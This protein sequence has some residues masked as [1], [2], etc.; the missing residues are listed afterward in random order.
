[1][2]PVGRF[3]VG[4]LG[5]WANCRGGRRVWRGSSHRRPTSAWR[6]RPAA[7]AVEF[8]ALPSRRSRVITAS[9]RSL[10]WQ[11]AGDAVGVGVVDGDG[12]SGG[13]VTSMRIMRSPK[14]PLTR[15]GRQ[16]DR[17]PQPRRGE[18][19]VAAGPVDAADAQ[20][21]ERQRRQPVEAPD[22]STRRR[23]PRR[24]R[25]RPGRR[26]ARP[27]AGRCRA[28]RCG[29]W[30]PGRA[31]QLE[32]P[33]AAAYGPVE[34]RGRARARPAPRAA[35][36]GA[37]PSAGTCTAARRR[38]SASGPRT[39]AR[40][41][42]GS[43]LRRAAARQGTRLGGP[44]GLVRLGGRAGRAPLPGRRTRA[45]GSTGASRTGRGP[46]TPGGKSAA[47]PWAYGACAV[48][49]ARPARDGSTRRCRWPGR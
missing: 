16:A 37:R 14:R 48:G 9:A 1:M 21:D 33:V 17:R 49:W 23:P 41:T 47:Q 46:A 36:P 12:R 24:R 13:W 32:D 7:S 35:A 22:G 31:A 45:R 4:A 40:P 42:A 6:C 18:Q 26:A 25:R 27:S 10:L 43:R 3:G 39:R 19:R 5:P 8:P 11:T 15:P 30:P 34:H 29:Q 44:L 28:R 2:V 20:P 38:R